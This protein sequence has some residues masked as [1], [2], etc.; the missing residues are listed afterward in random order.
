MRILKQFFYLLL[1]FFLLVFLFGCGDEDQPFSSYVNNLPEE[2]SIN[3]SLLNYEYIIKDLKSN[4]EKKQYFAVLDIG[5][6]FFQIFEEEDDKGHV[7]YYL[8]QALV[9]IMSND[10]YF[11]FFENLN[12]EQ[13]KLLH[14]TKKDGKEFYTYDNEFLKQ[15]L[16]QR[17]GYNL[18]MQAAEQIYLP[19]LF[20]KNKKAKEKF[21]TLEIFYRRFPNSGGIYHCLQTN[22]HTWVVNLSKKQ[23]K[24]FSNWINQIS[25]YQFSYLPIGFSY[26]QGNFIT[27]RNKTNYLF[28]RKLFS[29]DSWEEVEILKTLSNCLESGWVNV[30]FGKHIG[31]LETKH[32]QTSESPSNEML[33]FRQAQLLYLQKNYLQSAELAAKCIR[34]SKH[35]AI[36]ERSILLLDR[37][38]REIAKRSTSKKNPFLKYILTYPQYFKISENKLNLTTSLFLFDFLKKVNNNS[39]FLNCFFKEEN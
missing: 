18:E 28:S 33:Y 32:L 15:Q 11:S 5:L 39:I 1:Y 3:A 22:D 25:T 19:E 16:S 34:K 17:V 35:S 21:K 8:H 30:R 36:K 29:F 9:A 12:L 2:E 4:I 37:C 38:H 26:L 24:E 13:K 10:S 31:F 6:N 23:K 7:N 20:D 14:L 27:L